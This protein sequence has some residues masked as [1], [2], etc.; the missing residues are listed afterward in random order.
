MPG[1]LATLRALLR[2]VPSQQESPDALAVAY[3]QRLAALHAV[4]AEAD[5]VA[6]A[7]RRLAIAVR[8]ADAEAQASA[9][10]RQ[11]ALAAEHRDLL[12]LGEALRVQ[13]E[14]FRTERD[15]IAALPDPV[16][17]A[18]RT[19]RALARWERDSARLLREAAGSWTDDDPEPSGFVTDAG[20]PEAFEQPPRGDL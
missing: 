20:E 13:V 7:G 14:E 4:R 9:A 10:A 6:S 15:L 8:A 11:E 12:R 2:D 18:R 3:Q 1:L 17:A 19:R 5:A 16:E